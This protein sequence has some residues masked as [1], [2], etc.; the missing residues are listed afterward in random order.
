MKWNGYIAPIVEKKLGI[1]LGHR[2]EKFSSILSEVQKRN[3]HKCEP[4]S[5]NRDSGASR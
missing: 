3:S 2:D 1:K 4:I 5:Y